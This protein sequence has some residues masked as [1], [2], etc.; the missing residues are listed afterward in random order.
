MFWIVFVASILLAISPQVII[1]IYK[2]NN[3]RKFRNL[4]Q[5]E[6]TVD[7]T[8]KNLVKKCENDPLIQNEKAPECLTDMIMPLRSF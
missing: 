3:P 4:V 5:P 1:M 8:W 2:L 7:P 6:D